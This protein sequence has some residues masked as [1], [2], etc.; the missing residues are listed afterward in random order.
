LTVGTRHGRV[1]QIPSWRANDLQSFVPTLIKCTWTSL[2][3]SPELLE[4]CRVWVWSWF[5]LNSVGQGWIWGTLSY[6]LVHLT[7][8]CTWWT[9]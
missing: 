7:Y 8:M 9:L 2:S 1:P 4:S 3:R 5:E 6:Y